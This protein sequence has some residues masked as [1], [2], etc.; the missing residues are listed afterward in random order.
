[1]EIESMFTGDCTNT[2]FGAVMKLLQDLTDAPGYLIVLPDMEFDQGSKLSKD[3]TMDL[4]KQQGYK[5]RIIW[6]NLNSRACTSTEVTNTRT[7]RKD[8]Y[9]NI[10]LSGYNPLLLKYLE[11][12][13]DASQFVDKLLTEYQKKV[14]IEV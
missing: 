13:F 14:G 7:M 4:F 2:D 9:G 12:G 6:W 11:S 1:M 3:E 10:Y 5:T 8:E